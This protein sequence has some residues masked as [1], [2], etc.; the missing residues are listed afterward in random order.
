[1]LTGLEKL[2]DPPS[3]I[4]LRTTVER[5]LPRADLPE[6]LLEIQARTGFASEFTHISDN[7]ARVKD[8]EISIC[9]VL[10]AEACNIALEPLIRSDVPALTKDRLSW[11]K[12]NYIRSETIV[13][14][15]A[16]LV[17]LQASLGLA[18]LWGGGEVAS[19]DGLR[20]QV[21]VRTIH[22]GSNPKYFGV[23]RGITYYNFTSDQ[24]T[25]FHSI[26][27]TGTLRD[28]LYLLEGLLEQETSLRPTEVMTD[29][30]GYSDV[31][32][33]LFW[34]LGYQFSPRLADLGE[35]RLWRMDAQAN[36]GVLDGL[37]RN[38]I[39][40][41]LITRN[42]DDFLRVAGS[43]K[44]GMVSASEIMRTLQGGQNPSTLSRAIG[45]LGRIAKTLYMLA[46]I[47][48]EA[49]R[50]RILTQLNRGE[51]RHSVARAVFHGQ[52][53][54]LR[55]RYRDGQ[56][57]QLGA[58]GLVVNV[59]VLWNTL[60]MAESLD[61]LR[62]NGMEVDHEDVVRLSPLKHKHINMLGRYQFALPESIRQG[63]LRP[64]NLGE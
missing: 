30:H 54:E 40:L 21:P 20:F 36:Y 25:G 11:V 12:Q 16:R 15:N 4:S 64:L 52:R 31:V 7:N 17:D 39:S 32:F 55:Q 41:P 9:A 13:K 29:T 57:E 3:L 22:A 42:W 8:L 10:L 47:D 48:D 61:Y 37:A 43:L 49:Y 6:V 2:D 58:L 27:I 23:G 34:F 1:M 14:A 5:L 19:A 50:R 45:E 18:Q 63:R 51:S 44:L 38:R 33:G 35:M 60:Y 26:V 46:Y 62:S 28:S 56:E 53:G 59:I 24:F